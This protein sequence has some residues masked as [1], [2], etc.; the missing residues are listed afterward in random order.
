MAGFV[1]SAGYARQLGGTGNGARVLTGRVINQQKMY[2]NAVI[3]YNRAKA[4]LN[5][6]KKKYNNQKRSVS[7]GLRGWINR[8]KF[9]NTGEQARKLRNNQLNAQLKK[10]MN[11]AKARLNKVVNEHNYWARQQW[12]KGLFN[13]NRSSANYALRVARG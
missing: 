4:N 9:G 13:R 7:G 6:A 11:N 12:Y 3:A 2:V 8:R 10:N 1:A 5:A